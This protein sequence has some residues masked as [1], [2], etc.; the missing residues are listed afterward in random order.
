MIA[1]TDGGGLELRDTGTALEVTAHLPEIPAAMRALADVKAGRLRGF[2]IEFDAVQ[3]TRDGDIRVVQRAELAGVGLVRNPSYQG[4]L[5]E[6]RQGAARGFVPFN[7]AVDCECATDGDCEVAMI[8]EV[9][10]QNEVN[11]LRD[12]IAVSGNYRR[13]L[14]SLKRG[15]LAVTRG[16]M[17][18]D[19]DPVKGLSVAI[20]PEALATTEAGRA[21]EAAGVVVPIYARPIVDVANSTYQAV[22]RRGALR[23]HENQGVHVR[24]N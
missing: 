23:P 9:E 22:G 3:E 20:T 13:P 14:A 7:R 1:H 16:T 15:T 8:S 4:S 19:G 11:L 10:L 5:A 24:A 21:L 17:D 2:S 18:I 12:L 6:V